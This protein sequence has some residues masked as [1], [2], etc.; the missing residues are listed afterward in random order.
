MTKPEV[1]FTTAFERPS[2]TLTTKQAQV[3]FICSC[4]LKVYQYFTAAKHTC[5]STA[6]MYVCK[7]IYIYETVN[8]NVLPLVGTMMAS[9]V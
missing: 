9:H 8:K 2:F 6:G 1:Y 3:S 7:H 5:I 4:D